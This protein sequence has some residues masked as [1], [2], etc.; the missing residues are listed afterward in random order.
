MEIIIRYIYADEISNIILLLSFPHIVSNRN[1]RVIR[2]M[3]SVFSKKLSSLKIGKLFF[4][5]K[6]Y[7]F[8]TSL[9]NAGPIFYSI[10]HNK[11]KIFQTLEQYFFISLLPRTS[12]HI[13]FH[14]N[15]FLKN[16]NLHLHTSI[17]MKF[18]GKIVERMGSKTLNHVSF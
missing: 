8:R 4:S 15:I 10:N 14:S 18:I 17:P 2:T 13:V 9:H 7:T 6:Y 1:Q 3:V 5:K 16:L 12:N 11:E